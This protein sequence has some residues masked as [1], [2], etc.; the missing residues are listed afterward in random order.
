[1][2]RNAAILRIVQY[3][4]QCDDHID[5]RKN[6]HGQNIETVQIN[7]QRERLV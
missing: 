1:M 2:P 6:R 4:E 3:I 7:I 5:E